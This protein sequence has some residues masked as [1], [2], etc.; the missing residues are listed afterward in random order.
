[1]TFRLNKILPFLLITAFL[2][3]QASV[4]HIHLAEKH[5]HSGGHHEHSIQAHA[6]YAGSI[7]STHATADNSVMEFGNDCTHSGCGKVGSQLTPYVSSTHLL[8]FNYKPFSLKLP[9][10]DGKKEGYLSYSTIRL[11]APPQLS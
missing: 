5:D 11:R 1:M 9:M 2:A 6:H 8:L 7:D 3:A 10:Q 4:T